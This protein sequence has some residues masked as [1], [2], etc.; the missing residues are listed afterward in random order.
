MVTPYIT[1][2]QYEIQKIDIDTILSTRLQ[3]LFSIYMFLPAFTQK[4]WLHMAI[5]R[6]VH[7]MFVTALFLTAKN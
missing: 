4:K 5:Q 2:V 7:E 3:G 1:T 6:L